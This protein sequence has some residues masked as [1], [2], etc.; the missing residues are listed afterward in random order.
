[1]DA[2]VRRLDAAQ[3]NLLPGENAM[4]L[5]VVRFH[6]KHRAAEVLSQLQEL[7]DEWVIDLQ[8]AVAVYRTDSGRL[9]TDRSFQMT[10]GEGAAAGGLL[11][12][13]IGGALLA[14]LTAGLSAAGA[15]TAIGAGAAVAGLTGATL[16]GVSAEEWKRDYGVSPEFVR[17]IGGMV[18]PGD[19]AVFA[20]LRS[21]DPEF[22]AE[23]FRGYRGKVLW[24]SLSPAN[25]AKLE[26]VLANR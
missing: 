20:L 9:R 21:V 15:A 22:A 5:I 1:V 26:R 7:N 13:V 19:S 25:A 6:G 14:P 24:T 23:K 17:E 3:Q 10:P 16:G 8:D 12:A 18:Q 2:G 4:N 11:G